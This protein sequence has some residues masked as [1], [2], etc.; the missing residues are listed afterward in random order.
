[1]G[2][3]PIKIVNSLAG[4]RCHRQRPDP[5][6]RVWEAT[7]KWKSRPAAP[8]SRPPGATPPY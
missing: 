6:R 7:S 4:W 5:E 2:C 1:M 8:D 3:G